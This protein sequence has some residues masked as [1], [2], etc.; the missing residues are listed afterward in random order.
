MKWLQGNGMIV[1]V[2]TENALFVGKVCIRFDNENLMGG[3]LT[4][5]HSTLNAAIGVQVPAPQPLKLQSNFNVSTQ[6]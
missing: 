2:G 5:G 1:P 4:V 6:I 3:R